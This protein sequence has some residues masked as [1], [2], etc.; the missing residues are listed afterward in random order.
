MLMKIAFYGTYY[1]YEFVI[2]FF[3]GNVGMT[4]LILNCS[5][6]LHIPFLK[7]ITLFLHKKTET[8]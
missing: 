1:L 3:S 7:Y 8:S 2:Y 4:V 6:Y 5:I